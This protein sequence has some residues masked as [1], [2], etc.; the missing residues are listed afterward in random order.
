MP[1]YLYI[2]MEIFDREIDGNLLLATHAAN[3]GWTVILG[4][5]TEILWQISDF[6]EGVFLLKSIVPG[7]TRFQDQIIERGSKVVCLDQEGL[8]QRWGLEYLFRF[9]Q[10]SVDRTEKLFFWGCEQKQQFVEMFPDHGDCK[11][12]VTGSPRSDYWRLV[13]RNKEQLLM[14]SESDKKHYPIGHILFATSFGNVNH[15]LGKYG[16]RNLLQAASNVKGMNAE[17]EE[18]LAKNADSRRELARVLLPV[19]VDL[20]Q[21]IA[22]DNPHK[23]IVLRPHPSEGIKFWKDATKSF[24]NVEIVVDGPTTD[25]ILGADCVVQYGSTVAIEAALIGVPVASCIPDLPAELKELN[26]RYP[27]Q[28]SNV[29]IT[30]EETARIVSDIVT[31][32]RNAKPVDI[33]VLN[34][35]THLNN[36]ANA[37]S[38]IVKEL[39]ELAI[40]PTAK[41]DPKR[42]TNQKVGP[43]SFSELK[44]DLVAA[45]LR[46]PGA[47]KLIS[48]RHHHLEHRKS[49]KKRKVY[50]LSVAGI[51]ERM[52]VATTISNIDVKNFSVQRLA[53]NLI[54]IEKKQ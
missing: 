1:K 51:L 14:A 48:D 47:K 50:N 33:S 4:G 46:I 54:Q 49:Y 32:G 45:V 17:E 52:S 15:A 6:P 20:L 28:V 8:L 53:S 10:D 36:G 40:E 41:L 29:G 9:S 22:N 5:K 26:L 23:R 24:A 2:P 44:Q 19:Y 3:D 7:E 35:I 13:G 11:L 37:A 42:F 27:E 21:K 16:Q 34:D 39:S 43:S 31:S 18:I 38:N 12:C 30:V 25:W